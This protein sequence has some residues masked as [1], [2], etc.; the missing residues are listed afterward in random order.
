MAGRARAIGQQM[1]GAQLKSLR[2]VPIRPFHNHWHQRVHCWGLLCRC[3]L[4]CLAGGLQQLQQA[5]H[6][7]QSSAAGSCLQG[8]VEDGPLLLCRAGEGQ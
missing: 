6:Q 5:L 2:L 8:E 3:P 4:H 7:V 1:G